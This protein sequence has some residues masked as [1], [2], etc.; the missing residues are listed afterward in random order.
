MDKFFFFPNVSLATVRKQEDKSDH[1]FI[2]SNS[3][4]K[5]E[6]SVGS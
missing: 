4:V 2:I 3:K 6:V 5:R 1:Y